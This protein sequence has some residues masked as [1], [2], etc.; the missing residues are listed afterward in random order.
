MGIVDRLL[1]NDRDRARR[2]EGRESASD[3]AARKRRTGHRR[4][5]PGAAAQGQAW[6]DRDRA[7][8]RRG[9]DRV[10]NWD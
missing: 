1:G 8:E 3:E 7:S 2:Y 9:G 5:V 10:T 4:S 6:E